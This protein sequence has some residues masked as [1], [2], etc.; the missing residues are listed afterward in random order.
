MI[1]A[2]GYL[3]FRNK[4]VN[5]LFNFTLNVKADFKSRH[6]VYFFMK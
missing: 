6:L 3:P 5:P 4:V 2:H 1:I